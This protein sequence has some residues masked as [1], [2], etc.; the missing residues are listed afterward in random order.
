M[1]LQCG[2]GLSNLVRRQPFRANGDRS[3]D[4][5]DIDTILL[6]AGNPGGTG[7]FTNGSE[8]LLVRLQL[9]FPAFTLPASETP[10][11]ATLDQ[12][13]PSGSP[14][15]QVGSFGAFYLDG[16]GEEIGFT[17]DSVSFTVVPEPTLPLLTGIALVSTL[18]CRR[19]GI[20]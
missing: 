6:I 13:V 19:R 8:I 9:A 17:I 16:I 4:T 2:H 20:S 14:A 10:F 1:A 15:T 7:V 5:S 18:V 12:L 3:P 11:D